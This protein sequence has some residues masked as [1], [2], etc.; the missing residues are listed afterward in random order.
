MEVEETT[1]EEVHWAAGSR[2]T[3][4][5]LLQIDPRPL[6]KSDPGN[7]HYEILSIP[8]AEIV[9]KA[10]LVASSAFDGFLRISNFSFR[11]ISITIIIII[12]IVVISIT[13]SLIYSYSDFQR[14]NGRNL[15]V[16]N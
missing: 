7:C 16:N 3:K 4:E 15:C 10:K 1:A 8:M 9:K 6:V 2:T 5:S 11:S 12:I 13:E 14:W